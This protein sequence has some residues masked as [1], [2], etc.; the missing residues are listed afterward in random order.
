MKSLLSLLLCFLPLISASTPTP[1]PVTTTVYAV[2]TVTKT[3]SVLA[4]GGKIQ[5]YVVTLDNGNGLTYEV[6]TELVTADEL[7]PIAT[8]TG[9]DCPTLTVTV[10]SQPTDFKLIQAEQ[11]KFP[12]EKEELQNAFNDLVKRGSFADSHGG[13]KANLDDINANGN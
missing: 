2:T 7:V 5:R 1:E 13:Y 3:E 6:T 12:D 11:K 8:S 10:D 4:I 9:M